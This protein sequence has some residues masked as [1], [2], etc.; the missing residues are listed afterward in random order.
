MEPCRQSCAGRMVCSGAGGSI[1]CRRDSPCHTRAEASCIPG[2][3]A[4]AFGRRSRTK[5][6]LRETLL[7][8]PPEDARSAC[9]TRSRQGF[10]QHS[11]GTEPLKKISSHSIFTEAM[12]HP[13]PAS[14]RP[15]RNEEYRLAL[16]R[17]QRHFRPGRRH[18]CRPRHGRGHGHGILQYMLRPARKGRFTVS[19]RRG[20]GRRHH[21][22]IQTRR[23][24]LAR[25]ER[26]V[27][28]PL[29]LRPSAGRSVGGAQAGLHAPA[30]RAGGRHEHLCPA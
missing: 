4:C 19:D 5:A 25:S 7:T 1:H 20:R 18:A 13:C 11:S 24:G 17:M 22:A 2:R 16:L 9:R 30:E 14:V 29:S 28:H 10:F 21:G 3:F 8:R 26:H 15:A 23:T 6:Q 12:R 27:R